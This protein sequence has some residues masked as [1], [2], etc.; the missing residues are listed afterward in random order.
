MTDLDPRSLPPSTAAEI[1]NIEAEIG[2]FLAGT[3]PPERFRSFRL[4]HGIY[5]QRQPGVQMI[6][7]KIPTGALQGAQ[8][9]LLADLVEEFSNGSAHLTTRQ[10]VQFYWVRLERVPDLLRRL[11]AGGLTTREACG[12]S[13]RNVTACPISGS[14]S[15]EAFD[16]RPYA[17]AT[18]RYLVRNPFCQQMSRK[19]KI[20][21]SACPEDCAATA[22]HDI[23]AL[24]RVVFRD[25][26]ARKGF[27]V[28]VG[29]GLGPTPF[30]AQVLRDF[31]APEDLLPTFKAILLAFAEQGN[32]RLKSKARLKFVVHRLGIEKFRALVDEKLAALSAEER[33]EA[34]LARWLEDADVWSAW[35]AE[36]ASRLHAEAGTGERPFAPDPVA[37]AAAGA[38][39]PAVRVASDA[40]PTAT[41]AASPGDPFH[42]QGGAAPGFRG[43]LKGGCTGVA[44]DAGFARF[45]ARTVRRHRDP[46][47]AIVTITVP[48][49][50]LKAP[51]LRTL[52]DL[53]TRHAH[54]EVRIGRD[55]NLV[56][57]HARRADLRPL[58]EGLAAAGLDDGTA[59]TALDVTSCPG[60]D[61]C[62]L[63]I[64][65]SK[66]VAAAVRRALLP[67]AGNGAA[68]ALEGITIKVSGCPNSCGQHH[69]AN[70]GLHGVAR[71]VNGRQVPA[72][73]LHL[74]GAIADGTGRIGA[75]LD[76]IPAR[77]VPGAVKTLIAWYA[78]ERS[79]GEALPAFFDRQPKEKVRA[80][81]LPF[82]A[83]V[84]LGTDA[85]PNPP[86]P[87][88]DRL[89]IDWGAEAPF[90]TDD[91]GT[92]ECAG[93]GQD[94]ADDPFDNARAELLQARLFLERG[95]VVDALANLNRSQYTVARV[96]LEV[97]GKK[98]DSDYETACELRARV[99]DRG[100]A[101][102]GW[103]EIHATIADLL[104]SR[105]P[106][107]NDVARLH[108][109]TL[110]VLDASVPVH[111]RLRRVA[112]A[113]TPGAEVPA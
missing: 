17:L 111:A 77:R 113:S 108:A 110:E 41:P 109:R 43:P 5:G 86:D 48:L 79:E 107:E 7:V 8:L 40:P 55:Q 33:D 3:L 61:T 44:D 26:E 82:A 89:D 49:G 29:G 47:R 37:A 76:K 84:P 54:D 15:D 104:K 71:T 93:A 28:V 10:D 4:A 16:I 66:G 25:G 94:K 11:A 9:R 2:R 19:F 59:G 97:L 72:Y 99:I 70:I 80:A 45:F 100:L 42:E 18:W 73:Q 102:E 65:S 87:A 103:N 98:P 60:A 112:A 58:Y 50:D 56:L 20:A 101:D 22:I 105:H 46:E 74:G 67:L 75:A 81:L 68:A 91:L 30:V 6:R 27:R 90:S 88:E 95:Q 78:R 14:L 53:A 63:G 62:A 85:A 31:V 35:S 106:A 39:T 51:S 83:V 34:D 52:A 96:L 13:V 23:G 92:G 21:F 38:W 57:P 64:T 32:R 69:I 12:N 36:A 24:G 1:A